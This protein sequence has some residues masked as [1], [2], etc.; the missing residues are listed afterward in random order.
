MNTSDVFRESV[1][2]WAALNRRAFPWHDTTDPFLILVSEIMLRRTRADQVRSVFVRF[3]EKF[4]DAASL[5]AAG[6][7]DVRDLLR[8]LG[9]DWRVPAFRRVARA[10]LE[11]HQGVVPRNEADLRQL[12]GVGDYVASAVRAFAFREPSVLVD[13]NTVRVA[14]RYFGFSYTAESRRNPAVRS[15]VGRLFDRARPAES[16]R[17]VL[18]LAALVCRARAPLCGQCPVRESCHYASTATAALRVA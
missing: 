17:E 9:L 7:E 5:M 3:R 4:P 13:T 15:Q 8:P 14:A 2:A 6:E 11:R 18:D 12:P 16:A 10:V 1:A